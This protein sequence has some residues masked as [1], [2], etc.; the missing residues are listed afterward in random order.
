LL[1]DFKRITDQL[2]A[3]FKV[4]ADIKAE[5]VLSEDAETLPDGFLRWQDHS[6]ILITSWFSLYAPT[7]FMAWLK[8]VGIQWFP[9][10]HQGTIS[11]T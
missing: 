3:S 2:T 8:H 9:M 4:L 10:E 5:L 1:K 7:L 6:F 11:P